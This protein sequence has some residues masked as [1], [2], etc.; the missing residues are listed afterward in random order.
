MIRSFFLTVVIAASCTLPSYAQ[1]ATPT[2]PE[3]DPAATSR[4]R[5]DIEIDPLAYALEGYSVHV[6]LGRRHVRVDLGAYAMTLPES[7]R[8][9]KDFDASFDGFGVKVQYFRDPRQR[10]GFVGVDGGVTRLQVAD[11]RTAESARQNQVGVGV[12]AG[13]RFM[14]GGHFYATPW[15]G[16]GYS[17]TGSDV[18]LATGD[19]D[20][21]RLTPFAAVH[22]GYRF[23]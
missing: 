23:R 8:A 6:G 18:R 21:S 17:F 16:I 15:A 13:W 4:V 1:P 5:A 14:L 22:I 12:N 11:P 3:R 20:V 19:Y 2:T 10:G 9:N 7:L